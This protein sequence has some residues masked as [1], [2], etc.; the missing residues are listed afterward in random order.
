[1][2]KSKA[3]RPEDWEL[4][5]IA[6]TAREEHGSF[7]DGD[8]VE[9]RWIG[10]GDIRL[11]Q[12]GNVGIGKFENKPNNMKFISRSGFDQLNCKSVYAGDILICRLADPIGRACLVPK[13]VEPCI[14]AV[15]CTIFR[16]D[17][18][19]LNPNFAIHLLNFE[20]TL[21][22]ANDVAGG[23]TR[24]RISRSN[25]GLLELVVPPDPDEQRRIAEILDTA[26]EAIQKTE[27]LIAKLK[28]MK[29]GLL[30]DLLTRGIDKNGELRDHSLLTNKTL[31]GFFPECWDLVPLESIL[32]TVTSG[33]RGWAQ[34]YS[35]EGAKFIRIGN[36]TR[37]HV[38]LRFDDV[39][40]V[41]PPLGTEGIR[42]AVECGDLLI[43]VTADIGIIGVVPPKIGE[44]YVNQHISL[45]KLDKSDVD[46]LW[47]GNYLANGMGQKQFIQFNDSGAK[48]GMN[49]TGVKSL[50]VAKP[51]LNEQ[52]E[53]VRRIASFESR[54]SKETNVRKKLQKLKAGLMHDLLTGNKRVNVAEPVTA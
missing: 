27:A 15:D 46:P 18:K 50:L 4:V 52:R 6:D 13:S 5:S 28:Q 22:R 1:M 21:R 53:I 10:E 33:S 45:V 16:P 43:S 40:Y 17:P 48:A 31:F 30:H 14:T 26:D 24:Q 35:V 19:K 2:S 54:I 32:T 49:L 38:N 7:I 3:K 29:A 37:E 8:W 47:V 36:L 51:K 11:I 20:D 25:L 44:A 9:A 12:T 34:Y 41:T 23:T 39:R 42:T